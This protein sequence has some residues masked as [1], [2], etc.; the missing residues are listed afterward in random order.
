MTRV[1]RFR[2]TAVAL[3]LVLATGTGALADST[4]RSAAQEHVQALIDST[5]N[6]ALAF[7]TGPSGEVIHV[8]SGMECLP[9]DQAMK[10]TDLLVN[11]GAPVGDDVGCDYVT[12][13]GKFTISAT[14]RRSLAFE[15]YAADFR[16]TFVWTY[17]TARP[18]DGPV[19]MTYDDFSQPDAGA[20]AVEI[21]GE[22]Y[23]TSVWIAKEGGWFVGVRATYPAEPRHDPEYLAALS[24][25]WAQKSIRDSGSAEAPSAS[26][27]ARLRPRSADD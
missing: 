1:L 7:R 23:I 6:G 26:S 2:T 25:M 15:S 10:L 16:R 3:H 27:A 4:P 18:I 11:L 9:G 20:F 19:V 8:Q 13:K 21:N 14:R 22:P 5:E 24:M 12:Q 17:P